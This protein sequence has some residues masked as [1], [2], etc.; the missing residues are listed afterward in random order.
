[1][2]GTGSIGSNGGA[3]TYGTSKCADSTGVYDTTSNP[4]L[5][6]KYILH[7]IA[8]EVGHVLGPLAPTYNANYGGYHYQSGTN[9]IM[10]QSIYYT[11]S[12]STNQTT[13]YIG[14][15]YTATDQT[16]TKLK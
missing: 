3:G 9:V 11:Y 6:Q 5:T 8:H 4:A 10:D 12:G 1:M 2:A 16:S 14:T 15:G 7:T 13:F